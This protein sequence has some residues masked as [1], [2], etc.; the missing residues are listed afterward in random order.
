[1]KKTIFE[2]YKGCLTKKNYANFSGR[3]RRAELNS[4]YLVLMLKTLPIMGLCCGLF[5]LEKFPM[6]IYGLLALLG[7]YV[8]LIMIP[9]LALITRRLHDLGYSIWMTLSTIFFISIIEIQ[10]W[11]FILVHFFGVNQFAGLVPSIGQFDFLF[12]IVGFLLALAFSF[13]LFC[14]EGTKGANQYG[15]DPKAKAKAT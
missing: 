15:P 4:F 9:T 1:M 5:F 12:F 14:R 6:L 7:I 2:Y 13:M 11:A 8:L 3:A 10:G